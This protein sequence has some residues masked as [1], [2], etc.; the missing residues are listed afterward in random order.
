MGKCDNR[1]QAAEQPDSGS[2]AIDTQASRQKITIQKNIA[3]GNRQ[4]LNQVVCSRYPV[5]GIGIKT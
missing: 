5:T 4:R 1:Q 2:P 3:A